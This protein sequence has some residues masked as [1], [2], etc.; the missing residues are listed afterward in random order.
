[1]VMSMCRPGPAIAGCLWYPEVE[2]TRPGLLLPLLCLLAGCSTGYL[3]E[4]P[5]LEQVRALPPPERAGAA[6]LGRPLYEGYPGEPHYVR[7]QALRPG[8]AK[9]YPG[10]ANQLVVP[11]LDL[12]SRGRAGVWI[13]GAG[14]AVAAGA[15]ISLLQHAVGG[16]DPAYLG[17]DGGILGAGLALTTAGIVLVVTGRNAPATAVP[18]G[19]PGLTYYPPLR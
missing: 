12:R 7:G 4:R 2:M 19:L 14:I 1:M 15:T 8:A 16:S 5:V 3:I 17:I 6:V 18:P 11:V 10:D 9:P 13:L